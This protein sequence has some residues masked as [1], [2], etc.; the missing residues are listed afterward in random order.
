MQTMEHTASQ[1]PSG[2]GGSWFALYTRH[3]HEHKVANHLELR[4]FATLCPTYKEVRQW[5]DRKKE[6]TLPVF[7]GYVFIRGG[8]ESRVH[9][10]GTPGVYSI[11]SN[12]KTPAALGEDEIDAIRRAVHHSIALEPAQFVREG[13]RVRVTCGP[14]CGVEGILQKRKDDIRL[15]ISVEILGRSA[16]VEIR[17]N[18]IE[19]CVRGR[20]S[21]AVNVT[22]G[23]C[24]SPV[25]H[26]LI[27]PNESYGN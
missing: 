24:R 16:S 13:E 3:Q 11:V 5:R 20:L 25:A 1:E 18:E 27:H 12:G 15:I 6:I 22:E 8:L 17:S 19:P 9:L 7:P 4:G 2:A 21:T 23:I 14:L 10:L 26:P